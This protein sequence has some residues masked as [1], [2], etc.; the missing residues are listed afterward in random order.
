METGPSRDAKFAQGQQLPGVWNLRFLPFSPVLFWQHLTQLP[1]WLEER[2]WHLCKRWQSSWGGG[3][4][5]LAGDFPPTT[6]C[7]SLYLGMR[8]WGLSFSFETLGNPIMT[9]KWLGETE[10]LHVCP[11]CSYSVSVCVCACV[12]LCVCLFCWLLPKDHS[13]LSRLPAILC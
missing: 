12:C 11:V 13:L 5:P 10:F 3:R 4:V 9:N 6:G 8:V 1:V 2:E 7:Q